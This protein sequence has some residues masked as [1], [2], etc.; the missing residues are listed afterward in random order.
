[1]QTIS[2]YKT[3]ASLSLLIHKS[4]KLTASEFNNMVSTSLVIHWASSLGGPGRN[5]GEDKGSKSTLGT[6]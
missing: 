2:Q 5:L 1:M 4:F 3:Q 6:I